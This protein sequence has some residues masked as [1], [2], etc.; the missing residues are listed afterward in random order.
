MGGQDALKPQDAWAAPSFVMSQFELLPTSLK[1]VPVLA[2]HTL[3]IT[4]A[5][6]SASV[7]PSPRARPP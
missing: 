2:S 3:F 7:P 1:P 5:G 6:A 4:D